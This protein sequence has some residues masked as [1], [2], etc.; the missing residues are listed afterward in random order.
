MPAAP[1]SNKIRE[2]AAARR[3]R[4]GARDVCNMPPVVRLKI[5]ARLKKLAADAEIEIRRARGMTKLM[6]LTAM[7]DA[8]HDQTPVQQRSPVRSRVTILALQGVVGYL[9]YR[10]HFA[11]RLLGHNVPIILERDVFKDARVTF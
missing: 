5:L 4:N 10:R 2:V 6:T 7:I 11:A 3:H 8:V 9:Y 1:T